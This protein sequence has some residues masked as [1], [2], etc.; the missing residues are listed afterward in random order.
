[1]CKNGNIK[2]VQN[3]IIPEFSDKYRSPIK[4]IKSIHGD[5]C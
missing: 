3:Y 4:S 1:M 2:K 5:N